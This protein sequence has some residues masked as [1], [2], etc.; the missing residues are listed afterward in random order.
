VSAEA[1]SAKAEANANSTDGETESTGGEEL[2]YM[3]LETTLTDIIARLRQGRFALTTFVIP[4]LSR[5]PSC[6]PAEQ[7]SNENRRVYRLDPLERAPT[8]RLLSIH[9]DDNKS[10]V[11]GYSP[12]H[13]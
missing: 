13:N 11:P 8:S 10:Y 4:S 2:R 3:S 6:L 12:A 7:G 9:D 1:W 5:N